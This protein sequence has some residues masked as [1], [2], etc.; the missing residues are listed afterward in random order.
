[1]AAMQAVR[2]LFP[3]GIATGPAHC[4][5]TVERAELGRNILTGTHTWLWARR[6]MGKTSLLEQVGRDLAGDGIAVAA[7]DL[8]VAHDASALEARLRAAV[9]QVSTRIAPKGRKAAAKF[10]TV[11]RS[12]GPELS[13][14]VGEMDLKVRLSPADPPERGI[15]ELLLGLDRAAAVSG[16]R[17]AVV[18]DEFQQLATLAP[19]AASRSLEG[20]I[21]HAVERA[22]NV[23]YL[24]SGSRRH[25]LA[26]MFEDEARPLFRLCRKMTLDRIAEADYRDF[27]RRAGEAR[28]SGGVESDAIARILAVTGRHPYYLN[29]LCARLWRRRPAP[30]PRSV[31]DH[32]SRIVEEDGRA[33]AGRVFRLPASQRALLKAIAGADGGA[34]HPGSHGFLSAIRLPASTGNQAREALER[35]DLIR[36]E[37]DGRWT[38]V[39]P[40]LS[41]YLRNL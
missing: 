4:N 23:T 18:L 16:R 27:L 36:Q 9:E 8:L 39:D 14:G 30:E 17:V 41:S 38:L 6:R 10:I 25:L 12:L 29:A 15:T 19:R 33:V 28:W 31:D 7:V 24:F 32:W 2:D 13:L 5:R 40:V 11:F 1:M 37:A 34:A 35:D 26:A 3:L 22:A 21:R 20:A